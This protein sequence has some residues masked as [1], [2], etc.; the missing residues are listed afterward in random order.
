MTSLQATIINMTFLLSSKRENIVMEGETIQLT[1][2]EFEIEL[3]QID[4]FFCKLIENFDH[5]VASLYIK[6]QHNIEAAKLAMSNNWRMN[7]KK[8]LIVMLTKPRLNEWMVYTC[9]TI[10]TDLISFWCHVERYQKTWRQSMERD[11]FNYCDWKC[12]IELNQSLLTVLW[13]YQ[14]LIPKYQCILNEPMNIIIGDTQKDWM[15]K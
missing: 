4:F 1:V 10:I 5:R 12:K 15:Y 8:K 6:G 3:Q 14:M 7:R 11:K 2:K 13:L 9:N